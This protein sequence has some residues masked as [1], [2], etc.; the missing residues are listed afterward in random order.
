MWFIQGQIPCLTQNIREREY[1]STPTDKLGE[2]DNLGETG[3][4]DNGGMGTQDK[5]SE[6][7][8]AKQWQ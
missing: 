3:A 2:D 4:D 7:N 1:Q 5:T 8:M 6:I